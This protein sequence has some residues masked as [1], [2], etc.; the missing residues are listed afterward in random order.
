MHLTLNIFVISEGYTEMI[1]TD[2]E[3]EYSTDGCLSKDATYF[4][5]APREPVDILY[6]QI[7]KVQRAPFMR[8]LVNT[9][10]DMAILLNSKRQIIMVN[11]VFCDVIGLDSSALIGMRPGEALSCK[12][13]SQGPSGCGTS[14]YCASCGAVLA[15]LKSQ[16]FKS[17]FTDECVIY[18]QDGGKLDLYISASEFITEGESFTLLIAKQEK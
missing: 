2:I 7:E 10:T 13:A 12:R 14:Q 5:P 9:I 8:G 4:A 17:Q 1:N 11:D 6:G 18:T 15:I 16:K 3:S